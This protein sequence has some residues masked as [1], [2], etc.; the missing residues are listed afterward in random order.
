MLTLS[1]VT[2]THIPPPEASQCMVVLDVEW[3]DSEG[4]GFSWIVESSH[5]KRNC[6][7][8]THRNCT[9]KKA[10]HK[11]H[12]AL[13]FGETTTERGKF[14]TESLLRKFLKVLS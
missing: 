7:P 14:C 4:D 13:A 11:E 6:K 8:M 2:V 10:S 12:S 5:L 3:P 9:H 1:S